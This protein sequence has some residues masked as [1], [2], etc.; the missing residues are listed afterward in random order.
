MRDIDDIIE[1]CQAERCNEALLLHKGVRVI[2][3]PVAVSI[4]QDN[5][6]VTRL[7][8]AMIAAI[9]DTL[10]YPDPA[11]MVNVHVGRVEKLYSGVVAQ[12][13]TSSEGSVTNMPTGIALGLLSGVQ[14]SAT[15]K[16]TMARDA[17]ARR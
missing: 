12:R 8:S 7:P 3:A 13:V 1:N 5:D 9:V 10:R 2:A 11:G 14:F 15:T 6:P 4:L 16:S 17:A